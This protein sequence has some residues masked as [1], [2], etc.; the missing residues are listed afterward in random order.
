MKTETRLLTFAQVRIL[1]LLNKA[2]RPQTRAEISQ[3]TNTSQVTDALGPLY[4]E[5]LAA[6]PD[7]LMGR[8]FAV[9]DVGSLDGTPSY[10]ITA[11]GR[12]ALKDLNDDVT[13]P[14]GH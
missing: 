3:K 14:F 1:K 7:T 4:A 12:K 6:R 5:D 9:C 8:R 2:T 13:W 10:S 11:T